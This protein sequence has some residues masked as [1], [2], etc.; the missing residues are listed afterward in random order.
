M[1][2][3]AQK[4]IAASL[5]ALAL[6]GLSSTASAAGSGSDYA[7]DQQVGSMAAR[8]TGSVWFDSYVEVV[9]QQVAFLSRAEPYGAAGPNGPQDGFNGYVAGF[10]APDSGSMRFNDYV[11]AVNRV[12]RSKQ[13]F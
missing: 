11:D 13:E 7:F 2:R 12:I 3:T 4:F 5:V 8:D 6:G 1:I 10:M 9:N